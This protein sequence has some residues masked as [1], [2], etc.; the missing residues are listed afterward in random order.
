[1]HIK[2]KKRTAR[3]DDER[4]VLLFQTPNGPVWAEAGAHKLTGDEKSEL[5]AKL[6]AKAREAEVLKAAQQVQTMAAAFVEST[7]LS[8]AP[9]Q[10]LQS[11]LSGMSGSEGDGGTLFADWLDKSGFGFRQEGLRSVITY[12]GKVINEVTATVDPRLALDVIAA[13]RTD[14]MVA[15][16]EEAGA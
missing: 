4:E 3:I 5:S 12:R 1:M 16:I 10:V 13:L 14:A 11:Y 8:V 9:Q 7:L 6:K 2:G 15:R